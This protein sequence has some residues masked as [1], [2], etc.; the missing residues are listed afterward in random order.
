M[1]N[2]S[3]QWGFHT[4]LVALAFCLQ[5]LQTLAAISQQERNALMMLYN[6]TDGANWVDNSGWQDRGIVDGTECDWFGVECESELGIGG[7]PDHVYGLDLR[8]NNLSGPLPGELA[9][10]TNLHQLILSGNALTGSVPADLNVNHLYLDHNQFSGTIPDFT[11]DLWALDLSHNDLT[12]DIPVSLAGL[13]ELYS[14]D[15]SHNQ[16]QI[17]GNRTDLFNAFR[18]MGYDFS[19]NAITIQDPDHFLTFTNHLS[20]AIK[21]NDSTANAY[22]K[23]V[24]PYRESAT[25]DDFLSAH[26]F[27]EATALNAKYMNGMDLGFGRNMYIWKRSNGDVVSFVKNHGDNSPGMPG[28]SVPEA[29][30]SDA[31]EIIGNA[32]SG[33]NLLATVA[34]KYVASEQKTIFF[35]YDASGNRVNQVDLD[36]RGAKYLPGVCNVCHGGYPRPL[37][38]QGNYPGEGDTDASFL[39]WDPDNFD[40]H[41]QAGLTRADQ[42]NVFWQMNQLLKDTNPKPA[43]SEMLDKWYV[44][45]SETFNGY[46]TPDGWTSN[47]SLYHGVVARYCRGC[48]LTRNDLYDFNDEADFAA[49]KSRIESLVF[50]NRLMPMARRT[51]D[52]FWTTMAPWRLQNYVNSANSVNFDEKS[53][54]AVAGIDLEAPQGGQLLLDGT[55]SYFT[56]NLLAGSD[57]IWWTVYDLNLDDFHVLTPALDLTQETSGDPPL[58]EYSLELALNG[59]AGVDWQTLSISQYGDGSDV[60]TFDEVY[61]IYQ[62]NCASCHSSGSSAYPDFS[63][64]RHSETAEEAVYRNLVQRVN[65]ESSR[66]LLYDKATNNT[67]HGGGQILSTSSAAAIQLKD[68]IDHGARFRDRPLNDQISNALLISGDFGTVYGNNRLATP[69]TAMTGTGF[70][71]EPLDLVS[72]HDSVWWRWQAQQDGA[73]SL[74]TVGSSFDTVLGVHA[75][76]DPQVEAPLITDLV[77]LQ[78]NDDQHSASTSSI[79]SVPVGAGEDYWIA[80]SSSRDRFEPGDIVLNWYFDQGPV[81]GKCGLSH[82]ATFA[83]P[84]TGNLCEVGSASSISG[85]G[86]FAWT[87]SGSG[88]GATASCSTL[89]ISEQA[90][91]TKLDAEGAELSI[92]ASDWSCVRDEATGR[93]WEVHTGDNYNREFSW[94]EALAY[95]S[96][97]NQAGLCG[98]QDWRVPSMDELFGLADFAAYGPSADLD[99]FPWM[100]QSNYWSATVLDGETALQQ[101]YYYGSVSSLSRDWP[102][103]VRLVRGPQSSDFTDYTKLDED[104]SILP[105]SASSWTC[106]RDN[107]TGNTWEA[108]RPPA[109]EGVFER[110][111]LPDLVA[112]RNIQLVCGLDGWRL[113]D[114]DELQKLLHYSSSSPF[115]DNRFFPNT[116]PD[117]RYFTS[118]TNTQF[119]DD[120]WF[121]DFSDGSIPH[122]NGSAGALRLMVPHDPGLDESDPCSSVIGIPDGT[123]YQGTETIESAVGIRTNGAVEVDAGADIAFR[124]PLIRLNS[125]F[126]AKHNSTFTA[127]S[128]QV[129]C[130]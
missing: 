52:V 83:Y 46:A 61:S 47:S 104:G 102:S 68:W 64:P 107:Q 39:P 118:M 31:E 71:K 18:D 34:M 20:P 62:T 33:D 106:V 108:K 128:L 28:T 73:L 119:P 26:Q 76:E 29:I 36:G 121:V 55:D 58:G 7:V 37:D 123:V 130:P 99:Y 88:G 85:E 74:S 4:G 100:Q 125:G 59:W 110:T 57:D 1:K 116:D 111:D 23:A 91:F 35:A 60:T 3:S 15:L 9:D 117:K 95:P 127:N 126:H 5:P 8:D 79:V 86:P 113:P 98:Y 48:H 84:P 19:F 2:I 54:V 78:I 45:D 67:T 97:L 22:L 70:V 43:V 27:D 93:V 16:L 42:E 89:Q 72:G 114:I 105:D 12:G 21:E 69:E 103:S 10:L 120:S 96:E 81:D 38:D 75:L 6:S 17:S 49:L 50:S 53:P 41:T 87:C 40:F 14:P 56:E 32:V 65:M 101:Q 11:S 94:E 25:L 109:E 63:T 80:V 24:D 122:P 13:S 90:G 44:G 129:T 92:D 82:D 115:I 77:P 124:A 112:Q 51:F 66:H 30:D